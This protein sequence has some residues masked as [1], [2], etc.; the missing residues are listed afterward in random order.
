MK[1]KPLVDP[2][3]YEVGTKLIEKIYN[4]KLINNIGEKLEELSNI[5][6]TN[7]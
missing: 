2:K 4:E 3:D 1:I 5:T 7:E 6:Y